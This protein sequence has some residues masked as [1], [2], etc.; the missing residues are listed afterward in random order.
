MDPATRAG[1]SLEHPVAGERT[2]HRTR[3]VGAADGCGEHGMPVS[4]T[5]RTFSLAVASCL[6]VV[7]S[8]AEAEP[9][10]LDRAVRLG[11]PARSV[12]LR[13]E[14]V[15]GAVH[16]RIGGVDATLPLDT[17]SDATVE[18][19]TLAGGASV[20]VVQAH[21][22]GRSAAAVLTSPGARPAVPWRGRT[23]LH[24]DPGERSA[25][26]VEVA[27]R[28][29]DGA[30]DVVVGLVHETARVCG[31][32]RTVVAAQAVDPRT[33]T[34]RSVTLNPVANHSES[35]EISANFESPGPG[36]APRLALLRVVG[37]S[38]RDGEGDIPAA[39]RALE[40]PGAAYWAEGRGGIGRGEFVTARLERAGLAVRALA[41][42]VSPPDPVAERLGRPRTLWLVGDAGPPLH[43]TIPEDAARHPGRRYWITPETPLAWGCVSLVLDDAYLPTGTNE[44]ATRTAIAGLEAY[45]DVDFEGGIERLVRGLVGDGPDAGQATEALTRIGDEAVA[46]IAAAWARMSSVGRRRAL[47]VFAAAARS[48]AAPRAASAVAPSSDL[49][50]ARGAAIDAL[51]TAAGDPDAAIRDEAIAA[52]ARAGVAGREG[53]VR[54]TA[55]GGAALEAAVRSLADAGATAIVPILEAIARPGGTE[56]PALRDAL[57]RALRAG[58][59]GAREEASRWLAAQERASDARAAIALG[60]ASAPEGAPLAGTLVAPAPATD[61]PFPERHRLVLAAARLPADDAGDTWLAA[62]ARE[63]P[64]WMLRAAALEAL[65]TRRSPHVATAAREALGDDYPRVRVAAL[66]ILDASR[67][68]TDALALL[69][70]RDPWPVV[71]VAALTELGRR[72]AAL[73]I[74]REALGDARESVR[75]AAVAALTHAGDAD[76]W[77][78][79]A[80]RLLDDDE[81]PVVIDAGL[82]FARSRCHEDAREGVIAVLRRGMRGDAWAPDAEL[83]ALALETAVTIGGALGDEARQMAERG[84]ASEALRAAARRLREG[85]PRSCRRDR[86]VTPNPG[87]T[88]SA[89]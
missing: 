21:D 84:A 11:R 47:R 68:A 22:G 44:A 70:R 7:A 69:A 18:E 52:L 6:C 25:A 78:L 86:E 4:P 3:R 64:E 5:M 56:R 62:T 37:A 71:R 23:D 27:D 58:G 34:L 83:A 42:T 33:Q 8:I 67:E 24:G 43:V 14:A 45:T 49:T 38:S 46:P 26:S 29:D 85:P 20:V 13:V 10:P 76:A 53:L 17:A 79:V 82:A 40:R 54:A 59:D 65:A 55:D 19:V 28:D 31:T 88:R 66:R 61:A 81:W 51:V 35:R 41:I 74:V 63:A 75:A 50:D 48:V 73:P 15:D 80:A 30:P 1:A 60:L 12:P 87:D 72:D 2:R 16:V 77:P 9:L 36:G 89:P 39:P 57:T 32:D